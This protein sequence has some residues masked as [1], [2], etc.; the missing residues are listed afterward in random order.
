MRAMLA[1][2]GQWCCRRADLERFA[3]NKALVAI[4]TPEKA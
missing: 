1:R 2:E 4:R 3:A